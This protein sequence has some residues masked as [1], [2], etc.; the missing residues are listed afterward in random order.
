VQPL[1][2]LLTQLHSLPAIIS[3]QFLQ[4][5]FYSFLLGAL[6]GA[7]VGSVSGLI[8]VRIQHLPARQWINRNVISW[9]LGIAIPLVTFFVLL[10]LMNFLFVF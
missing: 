9:S 2:A 1:A 10:S 6:I 7:I 5:A 8:Q 4:A 3:G